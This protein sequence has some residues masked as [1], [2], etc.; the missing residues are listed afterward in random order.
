LID[1]NKVKEINVSDIVLLP[2]SVFKNTN[3]FSKK[4]NYMGVV[5]KKTGDTLEV[6]VDDD[7]TY[8]KVNVFV[9]EVDI[10]Q[11]GTDFVEACKK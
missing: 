6:C 2:N 4:K 9:W 7:G 10:Y 1:H 3:T 11:K 5:Q 8:E